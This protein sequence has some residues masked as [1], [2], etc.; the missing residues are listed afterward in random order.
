LHRLRL[1][2]VIILLSLAASHARCDRRITTPKEQFG[3]NLGDDYQLANYQQLMEYW[4]RLDRES[5]RVKVV[6][7][8]QTEKGRPMLMAL[9]SSPG[10]LRRQEKY[11][12]IA[13]KMALA[14][15]LSESDA[16]KLARDGRTVVWIDGGLHASETLG[17]QQLMETVFQLASGNDE[18]TRRI[19]ENVIVLAVIA[20]PDGM[21]LVADWYMREKDPQKRSLAGLPVLYQKYIGHDNNRDFYASTQRETEAMNRVMYREWFPQIVYNHHQS[22]PAGTVLFMPPFRDPFNYYFDPLIPAGIDLVAAAMENRFLLDNKPGFTTRSGANYSTWWNGGL[23]TTAYFHNMIGILTETIGSPT[24]IRIPFL[25]QRQLPKQDLLS[26]ATPG[27]WRFRQSIDY[28]VTANKA[29]LDLATRHKES[30]LYN[31]YRMGRNSVDR[32]SRD[33]WTTTPSKLAAIQD[34]FGA[35]PSLARLKKLAWRDPRGYIIPSDQADFPTAVRFVN[36]LIETGVIVHRATAP[37]AIAGKSYRAGS[38]V[39]KCAQA[40]RP[41]I[42]DMF[43]PQDHPH[44]FAYPGGPPI[45]PYDIAGWTLAIQMGVKFDRILDWF[46]GPF[47]KIDT[48]ASPP[49]GRVSTD[50]GISAYVIRPESNSAFTAINRLLK[51]GADVYRTSNPPD[52]GAY[53]IPKTASVERNLEQLT[54]TLGLT[55]HGFS[56]PLPREA[57]KLK[58]ARIALWDRYGGSMTSG[59]TRWILEQFEFPFEVVF[60]PDL[61]SGR[62]ASFDI[63]ILPDG[64]ISA[65]TPQRVPQP[66]SGDAPPSQQISDS[67]IPEEYRRR[68][69][70]ITQTATLP[71]MRA[72]LESGGTIL[73]IGSSTRLAE[74]LGLPIESALTEKESNDNE[75]PLPRDKFYIP[76][77]LLD[78]RI[79]TSNLLALGMNDRA[80]VMFVNSPAFRLKPG[81]DSA[82]VTRIAWFDSETPLVSGWAWGQKVLKDSAAVIEAR[83]GN[84]RLVLYGPEVLFRA[85]SHGVFKLVFNALLPAAE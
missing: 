60:P 4:R 65:R 12:D 23:R 77:S 54:R 20:N 34:E 53:Y 74:W 83:V 40:F 15:D 3:F 33:H 47:E 14:E 48:I 18:E 25:P 44:D 71:K 46:D 35:A 32:G 1:T 26:P 81:A 78:V 69:G 43:E 31:I 41:H 82:G 50:S 24:P 85:Q 29:I 39:V 2:I 45:P 79:D 17:A 62:L 30:L 72:F 84:G 55:I 28:S 67:S 7:I 63:L 11:R 49:A 61:D 42:L 10:N 68:R 36:A 59:W 9:V 76:G 57:R 27:E 64:A 21:D 38:F 6:E 13:R 22:G 37:F 56:E 70:S 5:D 80:A 19:L 8:G 75:R 58:P 16:R 52:A 66:D 73:A 51:E